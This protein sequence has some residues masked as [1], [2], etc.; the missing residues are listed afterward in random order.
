ML[1]YAC[2]IL[3]RPQSGKKKTHVDFFLGMDQSG[4]L[5]DGGAVGEARQALKNLGHILEAAGGSYSNVVK[6]T[7]LL[8][9][10]KDFAAINEVYKEFFT[11]DYP[12]RTA[13]QAGALPKSAKFEI[14]AI[15]VL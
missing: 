12:A 1:G 7:L 2:N 11:P 4:N 5:V 10:I 9:D 15:A 6:C 8:A 3:S 14:E 13:F